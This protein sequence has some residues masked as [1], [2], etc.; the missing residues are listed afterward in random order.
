M[1]LLEIEKERTEGKAAAADKDLL[2]YLWVYLLPGLISRDKNAVR[3][4]V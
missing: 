4:S 2:S 3:R 1:G